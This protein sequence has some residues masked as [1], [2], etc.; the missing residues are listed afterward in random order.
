MSKLIKTSIAIFATAFIVFSFIH[1]KNTM[2]FVSASLGMTNDTIPNAKNKKTS[3]ISFN[4]DKQRVEMQLEND[5]ITS[6][7][8]DGKEIPKEKYKEYQSLT[9]K[10]RRDVPV[11]PVPPVPPVAPEA[12]APPSWGSTKQR[13]IIEEKDG[14]RSVLTQDGDNAE[15]KIE[16]D[17]VF[18]NGKKIEKGNKTIRIENDGN[19]SSNSF[20]YSWSSD[21]NDNESAEDRLEGIRDQINDLSEEMNDPDNGFTNKSI[22]K[23][24]RE[25]KHQFEGNKN[26]SETQLKA[27]EKSLREAARELERAQRNMEGNEERNERSNKCI[28]KRSSFSISTND[29]TNTN[30]LSEKLGEKLQRDGLI[31]NSDKYKFEL[32]KGTLK[33]NGD[34]QPTV[35]Y[36]KYAKLYEDITGDEINSKTKVAINSSKGDVS[37]SISNSK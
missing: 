31:K 28:K 25:L 34:K 27:A 14:S 11:P 22:E 18:I 3:T 12:P 15:I 17:N 33:I 8:I 29:G 21:D 16:G 6:L 20:S 5:Q 2:P 10:I 36:Q 24:M 35:I 37:V 4:D 26:L 32:S 9:D 19:T 30:D 7:R 23:E 1:A 13:V